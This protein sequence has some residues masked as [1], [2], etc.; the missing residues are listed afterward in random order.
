MSNVSIS[1]FLRVSKAYP[2][3]Q[4]K[5]MIEYARAIACQSRGTLHGVDLRT[6][7]FFDGNDFRHC[8]LQYSHIAEYPGK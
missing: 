1:G 6:L 5:G 4:T 8:R 2:R 7:V 3:H